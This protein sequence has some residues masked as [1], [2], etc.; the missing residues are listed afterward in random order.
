MVTLLHALLNGLDLLVA[1][2]AD[3]PYPADGFQSVFGDQVG[4]P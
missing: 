1:E 2:E 3:D 4:D